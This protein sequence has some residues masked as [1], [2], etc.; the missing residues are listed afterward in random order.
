MHTGI[1][2]LI[3]GFLTSSL[4][5]ENLALRKPAHQEYQ[6]VGL[7]ASLTEASNAV[8][9]LKSD[10]S[11]WGGQCVIS[12]N[13]KQ[14]ATWWVNLT[15]ILSIHHVTIYY[16]TGNAIWGLSNGFTLR[17]LGFS[18]YI[19]NTTDKTQGTL[20]FK[21][22]TYASNTIPA[23]VNV[24]CPTHGQYV[25]YYN[26]RLPGV[27]YPSDYSAYAYNELC[28]VEVYGCPVPEF[29]GSTCSIPCPDGNCRYCHIETG[30]C[31]GCK[32]GYQG[33]RC[34]LACDYGFYGQ[35]CAF[36]CISTCDGCNNINGVCNS[37]CQSGWKGVDCSETC[38]NGAYGKSCNSTCGHCLTNSVCN[39]VN[40]VCSTGCDAGYQGDVCKEHCDMGKYGIGC[41]KTCGVCDMLSYQWNLSERMCSWI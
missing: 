9:G 26:E 12:E 22:S 41:S 2:L 38:E 30:T 19:S 33:H 20:C 23:V 17:F 37:G 4:A 27:T 34:E 31:Q 28:E 32:P 40:G 21:D 8:D 5:Y 15:S 36:N 35:N 14:T 6:Y 29:Y 7:D 3:F 11:V 39:H 16:R 18:L 13:D 25:I 10:L 24:T 1:L